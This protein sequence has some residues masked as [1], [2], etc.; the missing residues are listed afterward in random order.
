MAD[1][2]SATKARRFPAE[3]TPMSDCIYNR[4]LCFRSL[5]DFGLHQP[6]AQQPSRDQAAQRSYRWC[7]QSF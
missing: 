5:V 1:C 3:P 2:A 6:R 4:G 7:G